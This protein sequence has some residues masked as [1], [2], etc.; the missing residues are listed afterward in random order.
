MRWHTK[1]CL[2]AFVFVILL[3]PFVQQCLPFIN[4][5]KLYGGFTNAP[6]VPYSWDG[7]FDGSYQAKKSAFCNDNL[8]FRQDMLRLN[9]QI[10]FS[11][12]GKCH[13]G[14]AV[15]GKDHYLF[16]KPYIDAYYGKDLCSYDLISD[17]CAKLKA[18]QD[19]FTRMGKSLVIVHAA[20]KVT[21]YPEYLPEAYAH[22]KK[23][24][25]NIAVYK[26]VMDS[27]GIQQIDAD[28]WFL[29]MKYSSK[30]PL[31]SKQGIHWTAYGAIQIEDSLMKY[32]EQLRH[33][34][35]YRPAWETIERTTTLRE[36]DNDV[37][38]DLN[39]IFPET[40]ETMSYPVLKEPA[41]D[42]TKKK[43]NVI[44]LGDSFAFKVLLSGKMDLLNNECEF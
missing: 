3:L 34:H 35:M 16:L 13:S 40:E 32:M 29:S 39:L 15:L 18:I 41:R 36:G 27:L 9:N 33:E 22:D 19:T 44:Y 30:E 8:G 25:T 26:R 24:T 42:S 1:D 6:D 4:S 2:L 10:D 43:P 28:S 12:F 38:M 5:G 21:S 31:F 11:L 14:G 23:G 17:R 37:A 7:W 20:S